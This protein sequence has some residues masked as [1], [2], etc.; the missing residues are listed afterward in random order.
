M[1]L[2]DQLYEH[3]KSKKIEKPEDFKSLVCELYDI[4][5]AWY[6]PRITRGTSYQEVKIL[7]D[8]CFWFWDSF[9]KKLEKEDWWLIDLLKKYSF[10]DVLL[11]N[12]KLR[13]IYEKGNK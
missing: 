4:C 10:K 3:V 2:D 7:F 5:Q 9:I 11:R 13:E 12:E 6:V 1:F 8:K